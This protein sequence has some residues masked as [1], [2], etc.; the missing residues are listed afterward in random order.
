MLISDI[1]HLH[2]ETQILP[3]QNH[4]DL[5]CTQFLASALHP[6]HP[7][8]PNVSLPSGPRHGTRIRTLQSAYADRLTAYTV[9]GVVPREDRK[10]ILR[11]LHTEAVGTYLRD[12]PPNRVL[13]AAPPGVDPAERSLP[14]HHRT[15][16]AQLRSGHCSRLRSYQHRIGIAESAAC[17]EC[18]AAPHTVHHIFECASHP[19]T[20][21]PLDLWQSPLR[22]AAFLVGLPAF[23]GL[24]GLP[25]D[26]PA[27]PPPPPEPP[28]R[29]PP[30]PAPPSSGTLRLPS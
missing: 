4:L 27:P 14:R 20:L 30:L 3:I 5:L 17:P 1:A 26:P 28:P 15:T 22:V 7:S 10:V 9:D 6:D 13:G 2:A 18:D 25:P 12:A 23:E 19:T 21:V 29:E 8:Y 11:H 16:L 24:P